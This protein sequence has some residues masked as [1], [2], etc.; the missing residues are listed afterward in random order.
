LVTTP[1]K[2]TAIHGV[3]SFILKASMIRMMPEARSAAP[4]TRVKSAAAEERVL[5]RDEAGK[6][7][8]H[9]EKNPEE[10][11]AP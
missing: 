8:Q 9:A 5:E 11:L 1:E 10:K 2:T 3:P 4:S 7:V 6:N